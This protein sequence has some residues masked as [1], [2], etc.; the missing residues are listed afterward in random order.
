MGDRV[1]RLGI[2]LNDGQLT[3]MGWVCGYVWVWV[4]VLGV[5]WWVCV[6]V[7]V[8]C[9][10]ECGCVWGVFIYVWGGRALTGE[11]YYSASSAAID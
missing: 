5:W 4:F 2:H 7:W 6:D 3:A 8:G 9:G 10:C 1:F 11:F